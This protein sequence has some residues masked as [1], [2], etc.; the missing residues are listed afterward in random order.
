MSLDGT[1]L[2]LNAVPLSLRGVPLSL[3]AIFVSRSGA[4]VSLGR[5]PITPCD[6]SRS[7]ARSAGFKRFL[8]GG[9]PQVE[10]LR[11]RVLLMTCVK[12]AVADSRS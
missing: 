6:A 7:H 8:R 2:S 11:R 1:S 9:P 4:S 12:S 10:N 5:A 3:S